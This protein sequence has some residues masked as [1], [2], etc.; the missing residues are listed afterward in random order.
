M[1]AGTVGGLEVV[2]RD[3]SEPPCLKA[4]MKLFSLLLSSENYCKQVQNRLANT[5]LE[6]HSI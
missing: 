1:A 3:G 2:G 6:D 4:A 5:A